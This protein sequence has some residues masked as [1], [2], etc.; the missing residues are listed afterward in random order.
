MPSPR[1]YRM[2]PFVEF[3]CS[4]ETMA[5]LNEPLNPFVAQTANEP[6]RINI[7]VDTLI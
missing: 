1:K 4:M 6:V 3:L 5:L 7:N 2:F